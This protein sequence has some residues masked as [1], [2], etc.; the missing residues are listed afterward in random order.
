L[1]RALVAEVAGRAHSNQ[2]TSEREILMRHRLGR[3]VVG[4]VAALAAICLLSVPAS[5]NTKNLEFIHL[6]TTS[7]PGTITV[8]NADDEEVTVVNVGSTATDLKCSTDPTTSTAITVTTTATTATQGTILI[9]FTNS[10]GSFTTGTPTNQTRWCSYLSG[11]LTGTYTNGSSTVSS[12]Y[13]S[14][15]VDPPGI[16]ASLG[17][18]TVGAHDCH[19]TIAIVCTIVVTDFS[20]AG[21]ITNHSLPTLVNSDEATVFGGSPNGSSLVTG[22]ATNCG[23]FI[24]ANNGSVGIDARVHVKH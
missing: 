18:D 9:T 15:S 21:I 12:T 5:A 7:T 6:D 3:G 20:V 23:L 22:T 2:S 16:T 10:C 11:T 4:V 24:G 14:T 17:K 19:G 1:A 13:S 8:Y